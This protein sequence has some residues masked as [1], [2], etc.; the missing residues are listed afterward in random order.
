M[1]RAELD[2]IAW[3][4]I[5]SRPPLAGLPQGIASGYPRPRNYAELEQMLDAGQDFEYAWSEFLHEF[6]AY[7]QECFFEFPSPNCLSPGWQAVLAGTAEY[8]SQEF[9]LR[10]PAWVNEP[11]YFMPEMWDA[12]EAMGFG[13]EEGREARKQ[14][15]PQAFLRR[16][17]VFQARNLITL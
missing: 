8:L 9:G 11:R 7:R 10:I 17:V 13:T 3:E 6:F 15:T 12:S 5:K 14:T 2:K 1:E 4:T 16:N